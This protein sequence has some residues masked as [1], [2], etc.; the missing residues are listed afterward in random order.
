MEHPESI[1]ILESKIKDK[2]M[3]NIA[4]YSLHTLYKAATNICEQFP[5]HIKKWLDYIEMEK[6]LESCGECSIV[7]LDNSQILIRIS[8]L[9]VEDSRKTYPWLSNNL[10]YDKQDKIGDDNF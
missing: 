4:Y 10:N 8:C 9:K 2:K 7:D 1:Y 3:K 6:K 5:M